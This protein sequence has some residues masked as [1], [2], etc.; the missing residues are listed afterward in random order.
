MHYK[1]PNTRLH[2][3]APRTV[4]KFRKNY[5]VLNEQLSKYNAKE[6]DHPELF[7]IPHAE[8]FIAVF[9]Q[10]LPNDLSSCRSPSSGKLLASE[11]LKKLKPVEH[12][13]QVI[14]VECIKQAIMF[15]YLVARSK[16]VKRKQTE[17]PRW[18]TMVPLFL[19]A[20][21]EHRGVS[22][23]DWD[24]DDPSLK[25][26]MGKALA[27]ILDL[28]VEEYNRLKDY[29][30]A[31]LREAAY[32]YASGPKVGTMHPITGYKTT[33]KVDLPGTV[34]LM[35]LQAWVCH[36]SIR[37]DEMILDPHDWD[38]M[39]DAVDL[40][41]DDALVVKPQTSEYELPF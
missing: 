21:R 37:T 29:D 30:V 14:D 3:T 25:Y 15:I 24:R 27:P 18:S 31:T 34:K 19:L 36:V 9:G 2:N 22:Y 4:V 7:G 38:L 40:V 35:I 5:K 28:N 39:P 33:W 13:K 10:S 12:S 41:L 11:I 8:E 26:L 16:L 20:A 1:L 6:G 23:N 17:N 32:T